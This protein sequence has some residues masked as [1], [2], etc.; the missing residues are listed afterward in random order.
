MAFQFTDQFM[1]E[2]VVYSGRAICRG[3]GYVLASIVK[4]NVQDLVVVANQNANAL[5]RSS[6]PYFTR[7]VHASRYDHG[8]VPVKLSAAYFCFVADQRMGFPC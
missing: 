3:S 4:N 8:T 5:A 1:C 7:L 6:V 2:S